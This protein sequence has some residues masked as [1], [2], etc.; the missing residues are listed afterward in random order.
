MNLPNKI[1]VFRF[2]CVPFLLGAAMIDFSHHWLVTVIIYFIACMSDKVDGNIARKRGIVTDFGKLMDPLSDK[3]LVMSAF[4]ILVDAGYCSIIVVVLMLA[5]EFLVAGVRMLAAANGDVVAANVFGKAKT[6]IQMIT[7]GCAFLALAIGEFVT[8]N[9]SALSIY[10]TV[11]FWIAA[12]VTVF[13]GI[14]YAKDGWHLIT[15]K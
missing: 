9:N 11:A 7:T 14:F 6:F 8:I 1:T 12:I 3:T 4:L 13:S 15:T 2:L 10:C 5:R